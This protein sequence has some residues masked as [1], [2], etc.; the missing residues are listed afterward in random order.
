M[1]LP[2]GGRWNDLRTRVISAVIMLAVGAVDIW[3]G[4]MPFTALVVVLTGLMIWELAT[5]TAPTVPQTAIIMALIAAL[6]LAATLLVTWNSRAL[7]LLV[8][9]AALALTPRRDPVIT[10][11]YAALIL[12]AGYG[13]INLRN[14]AGTPAILWLIISDVMGYF[15]GRLLGGPKFWPA[16]SPKKTWSG[17]VAGWAGAALVGL[18][19]V[20]FTGAGWGL[21]I[22]SPIISFAGQMGDI[23][24]SWIKRRAGVKDASQLIPGHG[25]VLDRFDALIGAVVALM[26]LG[27]IVPLPL[28][29]GH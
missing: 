11:A 12:A 26:L 13:L 10:V 16:I 18:G 15:A 21:I 5:I 14:T 29:V 7:F 6:V 4:G 25:G 3:L 22:L 17:T 9:P 20:V 24:E 19:F 28:P 23:T 2:H 1:T 8:P 27:L